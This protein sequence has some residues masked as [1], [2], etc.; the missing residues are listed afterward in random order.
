M[1]VQLAK[2]LTAALGFLGV[3]LGAFGAHA[4]RA[5]LE[6]AG[7]MQFWQTGV[8]YHLVHAAALLAVT[9]RTVVSRF[10]FWCFFLGVTVFSGSLYLMALTGIHAFGAITP[11]GGFGMLL[12]WL[13]LALSPGGNAR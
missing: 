9:G 12:G 7:T 6:A 3:L 5:P 13:S 2:K 10:T 11:L 4:L 8:L 1:N